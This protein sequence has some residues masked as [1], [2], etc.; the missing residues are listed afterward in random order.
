M[1]MPVQDERPPTPEKADLLWTPEIEAEIERWQQTG[2]FPF[3]D[4]YI[5]P[6]PAPQ[7]FSVEDLRLIHHVA[8]I[9]MEFSTH[10]ANNFT[11]WTGQI[12]T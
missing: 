9:S 5:Y 12:P 1:D 2:I 7:F 8:A 11:I 4:L 10:D 6:A 3:P